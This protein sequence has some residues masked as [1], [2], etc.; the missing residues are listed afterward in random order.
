[1]PPET[2]I[3]NVLD[4]Y[5][6]PSTEQGETFFTLCTAW[7]AL[8]FDRY[9]IGSREEGLAGS[10]LQA[11]ADETGEET[12]KLTDPKQV[13]LF[14][15]MAET[16]GITHE[17]GQTEIEIPNNARNYNQYLMPAEYQRRWDQANAR[18]NK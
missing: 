7:D 10:I 4:W 17:R 14:D 15:A 6:I 5:A 18:K 16:A 8:N 11:Y 2:V 3:R 13:Q 1:V 12:V 9:E